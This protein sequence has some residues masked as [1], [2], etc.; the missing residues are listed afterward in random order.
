LV[1]VTFAASRQLI[2]SVTEEPPSYVMP[3]SKSILELPT[4]GKDGPVKAM[5]VTHLVTD[6]PLETHVFVSL[7]THKPVCVATAVGIWRVDGD[8]IRF[9]DDRPLGDDR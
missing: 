1:P 6:W 8:K 9:V 7:R 5:F 4:K 2:I 3:L